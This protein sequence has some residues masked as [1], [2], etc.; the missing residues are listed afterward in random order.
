VDRGKLYIP[1]DLNS[2]QQSNL[3]H[4]PE[5]LLFAVLQSHLRFLYLQV[6]LLPELAAQVE[7]SHALLELVG[8]PDDEEDL[9]GVLSELVEFDE[10]VGLVLGDSLDV[11]NEVAEE[12][13]LVCLWIFVL[14]CRDDIVDRHLVITVFVEPIEHEMEDGF[15]VHQ[16][17]GG[18]ASQIVHKENLPWCL[19][20]NE[21]EES[22]QI[23]KF[24]EIGVS[25][26][27][28][29]SYIIEG[30]EGLELCLEGCEAFVKFMDLLSL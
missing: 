20:R 21:K 28:G 4:H 13:G 12:G 16:A 29:L 18:Y 6:L 10:G 7:I 11:W 30:E 2:A 5:G 19:P 9:V 14:S 1:V 23:G 22:F 26:M 15:R 25:F 27:Q 8:G 3:I 17:E 24:C